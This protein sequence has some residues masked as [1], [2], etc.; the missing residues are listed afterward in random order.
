MKETFFSQNKKKHKKTKN[1]EALFS[2]FLFVWELQKN[3]K[4]RR[5]LSFFV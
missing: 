2:F 4:K 1:V 3:E 5:K